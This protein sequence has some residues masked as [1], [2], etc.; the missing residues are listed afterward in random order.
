[1][2]KNLSHLQDILLGS[3]KKPD[4][5]NATTSAHILNQ[6]ISVFSESQPHDKPRHLE[7]HGAW[8]SL[9]CLVA[10]ILNNTLS[11]PIFYITAHIPHADKAQDDLETFIQHVAN[12]LPAS[13]STSA[14]LDPTSEIAC[15]RLRLC[16]QLAS[17]DSRPTNVT[18]ASI[19]ALMQPVPALKFIQHNSLTLSA[20][21]PNHSDL[22]Q[23]LNWLADHGFTR[24]DQIDIVGDF[25][26]RG[27]IVD[28]FPP[29]LSLPVRIEFFGDQIDSI[30]Y[31]DL[32][33]KR[34]TQVTES[35]T[36]TPCNKSTGPEQTTTLLEYLPANTLIVMEEA[37]EITQ[38]GRIIPERLTNPQSV[39]PVEDIIS[40]VN[41]FDTL[42]INRFPSSHA[43][44]SYNLGSQSVQSYENRSVEALFELANI[45]QNDKTQ[46]FFFCE[47]PAQHQRITEI[48][49][50][51]NTTDP[52]TVPKAIS[53]RQVPAH[54]NLPVG[55]VHHGFALPSCNLLVV[56]HHEVFG[57]HQVQ[58]RIRSVK[59]TQSIESFT[60]L[61]QDEL[62][63]HIT[64]GI[65]RFRGMK[66]IT[67][68]GRQ[69]EY[70]TIEYA[71]KAVIHV[72]ANKID[73][74]HKYVGAAG[75]PKL[76]RL[77]SAT[78]KKQK[79]KVA[80]AVKDM[81]AELIEVQALR[82]VMPGIKFPP[83]TKWQKEFDES[84]PYQ[85][86]EDQQTVSRKIKSDMQ[87][88]RPM[89]R[90]LCGDVGY[91]KTEMAMRAV[92][93]AVEFGKQV[94]IL[95]PTTVLAGQHYRTFTERMADFPFNVEV[96]SRFKTP[97]QAKDIIM[98]TVLGQ[99]DI[100]I[101]THRILSPDVAFKDLG[102]VIIDE[103][104]RFG[105]EH[106]EHLKHFRQTVDILTLTATPL[107]RSM[108]MALLGIRDISSLTTP[109][110]DRRSIVT[111][112]CPYSEELIRQAILRELSREGQTFFVHNRVHNI[113]TVADSIQQMVP[114]ARIVVGHGQ[115]PK[116]QLEKCMLDFVNHKA[117]ILVCTTIIESGLDIPNAN[118]III[119]DAD[120]FGLAELH[121]L[122]GRVGR[123]KNRAYAYMLLP[124]NRTI[125]PI[126]VKRLKA[127]EEYSQLGA[128]FRI[129]LRD[130]EIRGAG[131][132][133]GIEQSGHIDSIG[134]ELYCR[135]LTSAIS[136]LKNQP[137]PIPL[138]THL[139]L[140]ISNNIPRSYISS[141]RQRMG[142]YRNLLTCRT[143]EDIEQMEKDL[144]DFFGKPPHP[145]RDLLQLAE[146]RILASAHSIRSIVQKEPDLIFSLQDSAHVESLFAN[147]PGS[148]RIPDSHT[149]HVRL[150]KRYFET[151]ATLMATLRKMLKTTNLPNI[152][153]SQI[154]G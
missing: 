38:I 118:T 53:P 40:S 45:A 152:L 67:K 31:F 114:D 146:I 115:M 131:N 94:A 34:S 145:V 112:V 20:S 147:A 10:A 133:L 141:S 7:A 35:I 30:R 32:D 39:Y 73:M 92:F 80:N 108:H 21:S 48:I 47:K 148:I 4:L 109:P 84:F 111:E 105:V 58:R 11:R 51:D 76:T 95:V 9:P 113:L 79:E 12:L 62:V 119:N 69:E 29:D 117:D 153:K 120:R 88:N 46:V 91:G 87:L 16:Q 85:D 74:V 126:A 18:V 1:M 63:V 81:A 149:V 78:W 134:Y 103:E 54:L 13:E 56:S 107:P 37:T 15:Q 129:A 123:Y 150:G 70:L 57:Q 33:T 143:A 142:V 72:P 43:E 128:G 135:L 98:R 144:I 151:P 110:L 104:Q 96:L 66:T 50:S 25:A 139:E 59:S 68:D 6:I 36:I 136:Q 100:L 24:T 137:Q 154:T 65:G 116:R 122:R 86:T 106:K 61:E 99:V 71:D 82:D 23:L 64:H 124:K 42:Y 121:Q 140:N 125:N 83:D 93:K 90:L 26:C 17:D 130:L 60:D 28:I 49:E 8:G 138:I 101:G 55:L 5:G 22:E 52:N 14:D 127:I 19:T 3:N 97:K 77:G 27:G 75:A 89:D 2:D 102:L 132:I 44:T 41:R